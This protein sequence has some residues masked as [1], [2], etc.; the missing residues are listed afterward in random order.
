MLVDA[1]VPNATD[2]IN[3][4]SSRS[5]NHSYAEYLQC[6]ETKKVWYRPAAQNCKISRAFFDATIRPKFKPEAYTILG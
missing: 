2:A 6:V 5:C 4:N 1:S 3:V